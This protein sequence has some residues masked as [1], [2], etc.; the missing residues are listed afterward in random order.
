VA[1]G[2]DEGGNSGTVDAVA[3]TAANMEAVAGDGGGD[4]GCSAGGGCEWS[5]GGD[6]AGALRVLGGAWR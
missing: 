6:E 2:E 3:M 4:Y 5:G 1:S